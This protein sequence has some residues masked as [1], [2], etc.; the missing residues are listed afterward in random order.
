MNVITIPMDYAM[1]FIVGFGMAIM[2]MNMFKGL[3]THPKTPMPVTSHQI[4][5][6]VSHG[7]GCLNAFVAIVV[8]LVTFAIAA[9]LVG[10]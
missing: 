4:E 6:P 8:V 1:V 3:F 10:Y 2:I 7:G 5:R 9:T